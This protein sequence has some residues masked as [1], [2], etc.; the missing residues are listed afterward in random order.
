MSMVKYSVLALM[1]LTRASAAQ[2]LFVLDLART[3]PGSLPPGIRVLRGSLSLVSRNGQPMLRA[4][5]P[6]EFVVT[7]P[8]P[9]PTDF[10][11]EFDLVAKPDGA[12]DD[13]AFEGT[14]RRSASSVSAEVKWSPTSQTVSGGGLNEF[15][16]ATPASL[17]ETLPGQLAKIIASFAGNTLKLYTNGVR[18]Y[19]LTDRLFVR[20]TVL[21]VVLGGQDEDHPV[22]LARLRVAAGAG[23]V[24]ATALVASPSGTAL[25]SQA[26]TTSVSQATTA[27]VTSV[28]GLVVTTDA[29]GKATLKWTAVPDAWDYAVLRWKVNETCCRNLSPPGSISTSEWL[30]GVLADGTYAYRV[31]AT[32]ATGTVFG[33][34]R[35][36]VS[37]GKISEGISAA[38]SGTIASPAP[39]PPPPILNPGRPTEPINSTS[40]MSNA[41]ATTVA[42]ITGTPSQAQ[43]HWGLVAGALNYVVLRREG[44]NPEEQ[45]TP[46]P[47]TQSY[48]NDAITNPTTTYSYRVKAIQADGKYG[49]SA[50][51]TFTPPPM[52]NPTAFNARQIG[53]GE[54]MLTWQKVDGASEYRLEGPGLPS[55]VGKTQDVFL[56]VSGLQT[57]TPLSWKVVAVYGGSLFDPATRPTASITLPSTPWHTV[58]WLSMR[59]GAGSLADEIAYYTQLQNTQMIGTCSGK[60]YPWEC[61]NAVMMILN[62]GVDD[63]FLRRLGEAPH[64]APGKPVYEAVF[65]DGLNMGAGRHVFCSAGPFATGTS[66][67]CWAGTHGP[68]PGTVGWNDPGQMLLATGGWPNRGWTFFKQDFRGTLFAAFQGSSVAGYG[69]DQYSFPKSEGV[70]DTEGPKRLPHACL[71]CHGGRYD[72]STK[73]VVD[74][75]LIP[76][77]PAV[78]YL[79]NRKEQ[80]ESIRR[81]NLIVLNSNPSPAVAAY[82]KGLYRGTPEAAGTTAD[83]NYVPHGWS[84]AWELYR[85]VVKPYC[86][87]C[88]LQQ[89]PRNDFASYQN[90]VTFKGSIQ[91]MICNRSMPHSEA[92]LL[93]FW[94]DGNGESLPDYLMTALGLP[95]CTP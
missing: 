92:A 79:T 25:T 35:V 60:T 71:A 75:S 88:H 73:T 4:S 72:P 68:E 8:E 21:R 16:A 7:L 30:D 52:E 90:F 53:T 95:R 64:N 81:I 65:A 27:A 26:A 2:D 77:D 54:V 61:L 1:S 76:L 83:D 40:I 78:L 63:D 6:A 93:A 69:S 43:L 37:Q 18:L 15:S 11:L 70:F 38:G 74:A 3:P 94:R 39:P 33:E 32:T 87:G 13:L 24:A 34:T 84:D 46:T 23:T 50:W 20:G 41:P 55:G 67:L 91:T 44:S 45:R 22:Y 51:V 5:S 36:T 82:I 80:E 31:Y 12:S 85:K 47:I 42:P 17:S 19:T 59:N 57:D 9:L 86:Q 49:N 62:F 29:Q 14:A 28:T 58:P 66:T 10:T 48:F 56:V 89:T